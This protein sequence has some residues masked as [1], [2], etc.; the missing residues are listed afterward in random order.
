MRLSPL[1]ALTLCLLRR[2]RTATAASGG[3]A[4]A[5]ARALPAPPPPA[6]TVDA[7]YEN[8]D[9]FDA[10]GNLLRE[11]WREFGLERDIT[12]LLLPPAALDDACRHAR[13]RP[14]SDS[15]SAIRDYFTEIAPGVVSG[16][17]LCSDSIANLRRE[18]QRVATAGLPLRRPNGM[19]RHGA[20]L[21]SGVNGA[22]S[23]GLDVAVTE[24]VNDYVR[25]LAQTLF[26]GMVGSD[27][28]SDFFAFTIKYDTSGT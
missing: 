21:D 16:R 15:E 20:I 2:A 17:I 22:V 12:P 4:L 28:A 6:A 14:S 18:L 10:H 26:P 19:N 13:S 5:A 11:A 7:E 24:F 1:V 23:N 3:G 27:D 9:Y 8:A 25:P